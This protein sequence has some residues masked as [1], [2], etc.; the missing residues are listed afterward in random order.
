LSKLRLMMVRAVPVA[1][2]PS[3]QFGARRSALVTCSIALAAAGGLLLMHGLSF[4]ELEA[5]AMD[6]PH[7]HEVADSADVSMVP[8]HPG[9]STRM[10]DHLHRL[11]GCLWLI[12]AGITV[13]F[14]ISS[15]HGVAL[16]R[17]RLMLPVLMQ[18]STQRAPP[19]AVRLSLVGISRR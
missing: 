18:S 3:V 1:T 6:I 8:A 15:R 13:V 9:S 5:S 10:A 16:G 14:A 2:V 11:L 7:M 4:R 17:I 19:A 12:T